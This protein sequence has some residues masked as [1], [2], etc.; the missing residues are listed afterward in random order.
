[1]SELNGTSPLGERRI[2]WKMIG[3]ATAASPRM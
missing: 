1:M 3:A 2:R